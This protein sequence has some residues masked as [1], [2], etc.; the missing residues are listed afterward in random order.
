MPDGTTRTDVASFIP[1]DATNLF[2]EGAFKEASKPG[3]KQDIGVEGFF[4]PTP[5]DDGTGVISSSSPVVN[6]PVLGVFVYQGTLNPNG[7]PQ[8]VYSLDKSQL[9]QI[10][11]G[12]LSVG[13]TLALPG[14]VSVTFDGWI[15]WASIQVSHDPTQ[16]YLVVVAVA[17]VLGLML[18]LTVRRRRVW[19]RTTPSSDG[20]PDSPTVVSV[21]GLARSDTG[22]FPGEFAELLGRLRAAVPPPAERVLSAAG[23]E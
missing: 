22:N 21:G 1:T 7:R 8:S 18:S 4:A 3:A 23:K 15:N 13:Q 5:Q 14:G 10:G 11:K 16:G 9:T 2:S 17:L 12:N 20:D 6:N 19:L